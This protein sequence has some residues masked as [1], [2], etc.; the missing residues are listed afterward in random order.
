MC[1]HIYYNIL[2]ST[3]SGIET[4]LVQTGKQFRQQHLYIGIKAFTKWER[5]NNKNNNIRIG[6]N[7]YYVYYNIPGDPFGVS[8]YLFLKLY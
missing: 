6:H 5:S 3:P 1:N 4:M 2:Y 7:I 8:H